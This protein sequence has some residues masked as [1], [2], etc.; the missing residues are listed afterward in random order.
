[1]LRPAVLL[2]FLICCGDDRRDVVDAPPAPPPPGLALL[3]FDL[4]IDVTPDGRTAVFEKLT[5]EA[6]FVHLYDTVTGESAIA[7]SVG[8]PS[9][10]V[11]TGVSAT[12]RISALHG[13]PVQAGVWGADTDWVDLGSPHAAG[14]GAEEVSGAFDISADGRVVVGLAWKGCTPDAFRWTDGTFTTLEV[15]GTGA[16]GSPNPPANRA[17]VVSDDGR[18]AAGFAQ[19][20][21]IDRSAAVWDAQG[22]GTLLDPTNLD[23]PSEVLA[24]DGTGTV[25]A[26]IVG[27]DAFVWSAATGMVP[28][29]RL[30]IAL[31]SDPMFPNAITA[32]GR[33]VF[34]GI[35]SEFFS[36]PIAFA[37]SSAHG[38]RALADVAAAGGVTVPE[39]VLLTTVL[40]ASAD[41]TLL[42]G[43]ALDAMGASKAYALRLAAPP[44]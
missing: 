34:G 5:A 38:T 14:C 41:G 40:A 31:P 36:I 28:I 20:G 23:A 9:R 29:P 15:L 19:L 42:I 3:D 32:D 26:G 43:K 12:K 44:E 11:A 30:D 37:W 27:F 7:A 25:A 33:V 17:T 2:P 10:N 39:G 18:V 16:E 13:E 24:I 8:D 22:R 21:P 35:G 4:A 1:M 6:A